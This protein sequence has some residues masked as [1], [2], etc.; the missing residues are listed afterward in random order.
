MGDAWLIVCPGAKGLSRMQEKM[1]DEYAAADGNQWPYTQHLGDVLR[2]AIICGTPEQLW[3]TWQAIRD[4][5]DIREGHGRLKNHF[6]AQKE[7][8]AF[9]NLHMNAIVEFPGFFPIVGEIQVQYRPI[10]E[11]MHKHL[12]ELYEIGRCRSID[13]LSAIPS[14]DSTANGVG[15]AQVSSR[16]KRLAEAQELDASLN[17]PGVCGRKQIVN[18]K[19]FVDIKR[20]LA[21]DGLAM[22]SVNS[23][24]RALIVVY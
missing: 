3:A 15:V 1:R 23:A 10:E 21:I 20:S 24:G 12:H 19:T 6:F 2:C 18:T 14:T 8:N 5:F 22:F 9:P 16:A 13:D 17:S 11:V 4:A 7:G